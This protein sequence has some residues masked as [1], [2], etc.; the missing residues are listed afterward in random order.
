MMRGRGCVG[1]C[2]RCRGER[3]LAEVPARLLRAVVCGL[4]GWDHREERRPRIT[5][6]DE[7]VGEEE[8][9]ASRAVSCRGWREK[10]VGMSGK[11]RVRVGCHGVRGFRKGV[12]NPEP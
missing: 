9:L 8:E 6:E 2:E 1:A 12:W 4:G 3:K 7:Q 11:G 5:A 10:G